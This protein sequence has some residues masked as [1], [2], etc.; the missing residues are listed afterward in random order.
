M[1]IAI[2]SD[3]AGFKYKEQ[4]KTWLIEKGHKVTDFGTDSEKPCDYPD[5]IR[6]VAQA[7]AEGI[8]D[9]GIVLGGSGNGEAMVANRIKGVRCAL[10]WDLYSARL[11][12]AHN[13][14]NVLSLGQR[15][16]SIEEA[17][18]IVELWLNT[19][20]EGGRHL[21]RIQKIDAE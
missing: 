13:D 16:I 12:R 18:E 17:L 4:I 19:P 21:Q 14:A 8:Y 7:V 15:M 20:F 11:S 9:R 3:H 2:G 1:K 6:P 10:C 5:F